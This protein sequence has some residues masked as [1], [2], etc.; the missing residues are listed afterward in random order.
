MACFFE[1]PTFL[2]VD[3]DDFQQ[4]DRGVRSPADI[5]MDITRLV[6]TLRIS[7]TPFKEGVTLTLEAEGSA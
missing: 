7:P 1:L 4:V 3:M 5:S 2:I 6:Q